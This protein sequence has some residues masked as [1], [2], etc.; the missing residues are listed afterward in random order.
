MDAPVNQN[1]EVMVIREVARPIYDARNWLKLIGISVIVVGAIQLLSL[2]GTSFFLYGSLRLLSYGGYAGLGCTFIFSLG[3]VA[4]G[5][6]LGILLFRAGNQAG[7][8]MVSG[9]KSALI[10]S[11]SNLKIYFIITGVFLLIGI[12]IT[13]ASICIALIVIPMGINM[14]NFGY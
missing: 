7:Q 12:I 4:L 14:L 6:Y 13:V 8:A 2:L 5:I 3:F 1:D 11:L 9:S 10:T